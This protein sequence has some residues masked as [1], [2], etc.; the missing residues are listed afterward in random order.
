MS[1]PGLCKREHWPIDDSETVDD[2][3]KAKDEIKQYIS[4]I[5][6]KR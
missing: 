5:I 1:C 6:E 2:F 4:A 3:C